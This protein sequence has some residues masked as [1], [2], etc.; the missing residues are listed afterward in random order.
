[1]SVFSRDNPPKVGDIVRCVNN[2]EH[3]DQPMTRLPLVKGKLYKVVSSITGINSRSIGVEPLLSDAEHEWHQGRR[4][5]YT[6]FEP[7]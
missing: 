7:L 3:Q 1:M 6:R 4:H 5:S 2:T